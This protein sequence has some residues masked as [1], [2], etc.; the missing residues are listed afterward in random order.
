MNLAD[1][2]Y[3]L[4][5]DPKRFWAR[6]NQNS[7]EPICPVCGVCVETNGHYGEG[8]RKMY[9]ADCVREAY[10]QQ[11]AKKKTAKCF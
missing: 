11:R 3:V 8:S 4:V 1:E 9:C 6:L 5:D 7:A 2:V 10:E